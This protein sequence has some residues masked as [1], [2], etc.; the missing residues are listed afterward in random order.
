LA[1]PSDPLPAILR[2]AADPAAAPTA[3]SATAAEIDAVMSVLELLGV[4]RAD[5]S[6]QPSSASASYFL[7]SL[8]DFAERGLAVTSG[9]DRTLPPSWSEEDLPNGPRLTLLLETFRSKLP[10][11]SPLRHTEVAQ[12]VIKGRMW[13]PLNDRYLVRWDAKSHAYQLVGGHRRS[14]DPSMDDTLWR[15]LIEELPGM[16]ITRT[17]DSIVPLATSSTVQVS[18]TYGALTE[19]RMT[20]YRFHSHLSRPVLSDQERWVSARELV[21]GRARG[22]R[23]IDTSGLNHAISGLEAFLATQ[24]PTFHRLL[25]PPRRLLWPW[26]VGIAAVVVAVLGVV[27]DL[28]GIIDFVTPQPPG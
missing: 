16:A 22:G 5:G 25:R 11:P 24:P 1:H 9:W 7:K 3:H 10:S 2:N 19:Y 4:I 27:A 28:L 15:E 14:T 17:A 6:R 20:F 23:R 13:W 21:D 26:I 8:A 12:A 18:A